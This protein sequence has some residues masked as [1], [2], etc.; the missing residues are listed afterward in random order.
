MVS[1]EKHHLLN[2]DPETA[3]KETFVTTN[4]AL[5]VTP[6]KYMT[7]GT[8]VVAVYVK[9]TAMYIANVGDS[10]AVLAVAPAAGDKYEAKM[11]SRDHKPDMPEEME[12][13]VSWG[14]FVSP[15]PEPGMSSRVWLD[16][17]F[18]L[19]GL[20]M[21][22]SIGTRPHASVCLCLFRS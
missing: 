15:C 7:S 19:I 8:T 6:I 13:I 10:R 17:D 18:Q 5:M 4:T 3:L 9:G 22:R 20:A 21:S 2:N 12:R 16:K 1:L 14:G 11:L